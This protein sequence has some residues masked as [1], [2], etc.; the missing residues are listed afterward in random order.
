MH[1]DNAAKHKTGTY[2]LVGQKKACII[3]RGDVF[4]LAI[5]CKDRAFDMNKDR[6]TLTFEFG[7]NPSV[8]KGTKAVTEMLQK[9]DFSLG[10]SWE[11]LFDRRLGHRVE[12]MVR[13]P[14]NIPVG[15][16]RLSVD[17]WQ[18][19]PTRLTHQ[20]TFR[21]EEQFYILFNPFQESK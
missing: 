5:K 7:T 18:E 16:W 13:V 12:V 14:V 10:G 4:S 19:G 2:E 11:T 1:A 21:T 15:L 20:R 6:I 9:R 17:T 3:R 8:V